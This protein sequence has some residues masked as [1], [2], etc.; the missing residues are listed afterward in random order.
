[1]QGFISNRM[2]H[3]ATDVHVVYVRLRA[4]RANIRAGC[5]VSQGSNSQAQYVRAHTRAQR[6]HRQQLSQRRELPSL[7]RIGILPSAHTSQSAI[8]GSR[9]PPAVSTPQAQ[10]RA[11]PALA[12][13]RAA[14]AHL[15]PPSVAPLVGCPSSIGCPACH[16]SR[17]RAT[18]EPTPLDGTG[19][20]TRSARSA[21]ALNLAAPRSQCTPRRA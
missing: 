9:S 6:K 7:A 17:H 11:P 14:S 4:G 12:H 13:Q 16:P 5:G 2:P 10:S 20:S 1:M 3:P 8:K 19:S 21:P 15:S 18:Q